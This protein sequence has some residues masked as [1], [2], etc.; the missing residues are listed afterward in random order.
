MYSIEGTLK[1]FSVFIL[2][3]LVATILTTVPARALDS[4]EDI[5]EKHADWVLHLNTEILEHYLQYK[6]TTLHPVAAVNVTYKLR[7]P[8][9]AQF[10]EV[11]K[12]ENLWFHQGHGIGVE[13]YEHLKLPE[14]SHGIAI[15]D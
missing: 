4:E 6:G 7:D 14:G 5:Q 1:K 2:T 12:Y 13:R 3:W 8:H 15:V 9:T 11:R 10:G